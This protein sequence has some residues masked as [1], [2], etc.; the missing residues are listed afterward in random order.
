MIDIMNKLLLTL[1]FAAMQ[2]SVLNAQDK[3]DY[4]T[5]KAEVMGDKYTYLIEIPSHTNRIIIHNKS[6]LKREWTIIDDKGRLIGGTLVF[7]SV[8]KIENPE[9]I[10]EVIKEIFTQEEL[11]SMLS[12]YDP[13]KTVSPNSIANFGF[14]FTSNKHTKKI[15]EVVDIYID[16]VPTFRA[17]PPQRIEQLED[18]LKSKVRFRV[19]E[20]REKLIGQNYDVFP[21]CEAHVH[22]IDLIDEQ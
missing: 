18:L 16:N 17:I 9:I 12:E 1:L 20:K 22:L 21:V 19:N 10:K 6:S 5:E 4:Y 2:L 11:K 14:L 13:Y 7:D 8:M 3:A 15:E